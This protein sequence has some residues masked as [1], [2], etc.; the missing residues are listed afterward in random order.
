MFCFLKKSLFKATSVLE[1][2][3]KIS[4]Y[5]ASPSKMFS[6]RPELPQVPLGAYVGHLFIHYVTDIYW[7]APM[8]EVFC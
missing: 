2:N 7:E 4:L 1:T 5:P 3:S 8:S 6:P